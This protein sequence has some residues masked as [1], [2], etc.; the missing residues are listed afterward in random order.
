MKNKRASSLSKSFIAYSTLTAIF[1]GFLFLIWYIQDPAR[2]GRLDRYILYSIDDILR[3]C[4][5]RNS[6]GDVFIFFSIYLKFLYTL[7]ATLFFHLIPIGMSSLRLMNSI[8]SIATL[9]ILYKLT[10]LLG[11]EEEF[12]ILSILITAI[13]PVYFLLS[14]STYA[15]P[16]FA[17]FLIS[18][19]YALYKERYGLFSVLISLTPFLRLEGLLYLELGIFIL[20][21]KRPRLK[22]FL[23]LLTPTL[24]WGIF[25]FIFLKRYL[26]Q[27]FGY[28][29]VYL[30]RPPQDAIIYLSQVSF[31]YYIGFYPVLLLSIIGIAVKFFDKKYILILS[32]LV[33]QLVFISIIYI[34]D[35]LI[36]GGLHREFRHFMP[37][38]PILAIYQVIAIRWSLKKLIKNNIALMASLALIFTS[39]SVFSILQLKQFQKSPKLIDDALSYKQEKELQSVSRW[40]AYYLKENGINNVYGEAIE[41][42]NEPIRKLWMYLPKEIK[43]YFSYM[44]FQVFDVLTW[45][46]LPNHRVSGVLVTMFPKSR[47][48]F[49]QP[50]YKLIK[51]FP[52]IP[53]Y[54][55][56]TD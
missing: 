36:T 8:F 1:L 51:A 7:I 33:V 12:S 9:F 5:I 35:Y 15:E 47:E 45:K 25:N 18:S 19:L 11:F 29:I 17:F 42:I 20:L 28:N 13:F 21:F 52:G 26:P 41:L 34:M 55:Y 46:V 27:I 30:P 54:F 43:M 56:A 48:S 31:M 49:I 10:K 16:I 53:L 38:I 44:N 6:L 32:Y 22:Y 23:I 50:Y 40:L 4:H 39:L 24:L 3:Y 2:A 14:I 37:V